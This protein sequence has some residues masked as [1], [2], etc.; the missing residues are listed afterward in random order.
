MDT[1]RNQLKSD[2]KDLL[3]QVMVRLEGFKELETQNDDDGVTRFVDHDSETGKYVPNNKDDIY[4]S[5]VKALVGELISGDSYQ[6]ETMM[7]K[8][9][10][11][12]CY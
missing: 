1:N 8:Y 4:L 6:A 3:N 2:V 11:S 12:T 9:Y 7:T 5:S 10:T